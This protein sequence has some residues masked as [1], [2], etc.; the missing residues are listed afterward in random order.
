VI[1]TY[2]SVLA[3]CGASLLVGQAAAAVC[4][5][6][7][8]SW[9]SPAVGLALVCALAW[10][11]VRLP[12][13]GVAS[14][15]AILTVSIASAIYLRGRVGQLA[16]GATGAVPVALV[17]LAAASLPFVVEG[18][19]GI[20]GTSFNPDMSQHLLAAARLGEG[21]ETQLLTQ[22][23]PLGPHSLVVALHDGL[24][25]GLVQGF[26]GLTIATAV[27]ACLTAMGAISSTTGARRIAGALLIGLPYMVASYFA[28]GA[29][30]ETMQALFFLAFAV[31]LF[32][33][34]REGP[35]PGWRGLPLRGVPLAFLAAG[36]VFTYSFPGLAWLGGALAGWACL[37]LLWARAPADDVLRVSL[38]PLLLAV[39]VLAV[40]TAPELGRMIEFAGFETFDPAG[41]GLGNLFGQISPFEALGI[42]P[43]GD[44][45]LTPGDGAVPAAG[46]YLGVGLG[47]I[48]LAIGA[49]WALSHRE[50]AFL[51]AAGAAVVVYA[52]ARIGGTAYTAAKAVAMIAPVATVLILRP[53][54]VPTRA[55]L[56]PRRSLRDLPAQAALT[57][58]AGAAF[59]LAAG[60]C[61]LLALANAPVGPTSYTT[62][63]AELRREVGPGPTVILAPPELLEEEHGRPYLAWEL[64]G[65]RLCVFPESEA[66]GAA[67]P[68]VRFVIAKRSQSAPFRRLHAARVIGDYRLWERRDRARGRSECPLIAVRQARRGSRQE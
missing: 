62:A 58:L 27:L 11:T 53:L 14:A 19:F 9:L 51:A 5:Q 50:S 17:A 22:G 28:Q 1:G 55:S 57:P 33:L 38:R 10:A 60:G 16:A 48:L 25:V 42:W 56:A 68:G 24:G 2:A 30:K 49:V 54:L 67:P 21:V 34:S 41:P 29:F 46:F 15:L 61:A 8:W 7:R 3:V 35:R 52:M 63:L 66:G 44:F 40:L 23:Y 26:G 59:A 37:E 12:G 13:E 20:L 4:G 31:G 64:R 32:E 43:S 6:R 47:L 18:R 39:L 45:R 36:S 65:G